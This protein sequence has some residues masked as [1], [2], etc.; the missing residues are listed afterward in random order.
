MD[1]FCRLVLHMAA[2]PYIMNRNHFVRLQIL[3]SVSLEERSIF[4]VSNNFQGEVGLVD[5]GMAD[6]LNNNVL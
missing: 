6:I 1:L 3:H 2:S 4:P 5:P